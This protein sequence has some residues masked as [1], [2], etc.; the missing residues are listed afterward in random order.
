MIHVYLSDIGEGWELIQHFPLRVGYQSGGS[1]FLL[2]QFIV[3]NRG[4]NIYGTGVTLAL[5][6]ADARAMLVDRWIAHQSLEAVLSPLLKS[7]LEYMRRFIRPA[8]HDLA[9]IAIK[10]GE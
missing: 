4:A 5:A 10:R 9:A 6:K 1:G 8:S 7:E 2:G 3:S